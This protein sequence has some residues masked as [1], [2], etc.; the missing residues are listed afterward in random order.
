MSMKEEEE[1]GVRG[2]ILGEGEK[3]EDFKVIYE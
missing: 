3:N 2:V 1:N